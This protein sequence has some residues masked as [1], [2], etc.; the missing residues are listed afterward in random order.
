MNPKVVTILGAT[1]S[2]GSQALEVI[3][4]YPEHFQLGFITTHHNI[5]ALHAILERFSPKG[6]VICDTAACAQFRQETAYTGTI[7]CGSDA[8]LTAATDSDNDLVISALVGF[9]GVHPT[10]AAIQQGINVALANKEVLV[11]AGELMMQTAKA[12]KAAIL[13]I[14]SEHSA[15]AQCL[16]GES[17][18]SV[19]KIILTAS[20][21]PFRTFSL[22]QLHT[23]TPAS[24]LQHPNWKM[25]S[26]ITI[27]SA[28]LMNKGLEMI[29]ARWLFDLRP[30]QIDVLI[31]P[32]SIIHSLVQ[33]IDGSLKA[34]L[35]LPD[36]RLPILYALTFPERLPT[37]FPRANLAD[38]RTLTFEPPDEH[39]FPCLRLAKEALQM[40]GSAPTILNAANEVAVAAFLKEHI[41]FTDIPTVIAETLEKIA[42]MSK[43]SLADITAI[44]STARQVA[45]HIVETIATK[46]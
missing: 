2:I 19:E 4:L 34:Q 12:T 20:G 37:P 24:A 11:S 1:G 18:A 38:I 32:Q 23:V 5:R 35:G 22:E 9:A 45:Q 44:D 14:D 43:P 31:H 39:R 3:A 30:E 33:F 21:G 46:V 6:I 28:T 40:G 27:D 13:P 16:I 36:M 10:F 17:L 15:I 7:L 8:L 26:K 41:R 25:G 42:P 29:E